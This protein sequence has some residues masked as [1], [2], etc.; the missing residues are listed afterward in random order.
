MS[1]SNSNWVYDEE[2]EAV[3]EKNC[4]ACK[5]SSNG[6]QWYFEPDGVGDCE[7]PLPA[8]LNFASRTLP[9]HG[10]DKCSAF[11]QRELDHSL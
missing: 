1:N 11:E 2:L 5:Y 8:F 10:F 9:Y 3:D 6:H 4:K 7:F